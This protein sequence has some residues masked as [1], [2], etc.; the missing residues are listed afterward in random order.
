[1]SEMSE[2]SKFYFHLA[3]LTT[4]VNKDTPRKEPFSLPAYCGEDA[5]FNR[6]CTT[7][8]QRIFPE[9]EHYLIAQSLLFHVTCFRC[10]ICTTCCDVT[11]YCYV[12]EH[13]KF[14][15]LRHYHEM[16]AAGIGIGIGDEGRVVNGTGPGAFA[17]R[18]VCCELC[19]NSV[20]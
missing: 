6:R 2:N 5:I 20:I 1:M 18:V 15:C 16:V 19:I 12:T 14:Y 4:S 13:E 7:C 8:H 9:G 10:S 3:S 11:D 17:G